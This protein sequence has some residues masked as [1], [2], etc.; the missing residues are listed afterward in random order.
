[1]S[2]P[3]TALLAR[4]LSFAGTKVPAKTQNYLD[5]KYVDSSSSKWIDVPNP[6][7]NE[8]VTKVPQ[9]TQAEME[10]AVESAKAAFKGWSQTSP[11]RRQEVMFKYQALI[12]ENLVSL[13]MF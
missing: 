8:V 2:S 6:A 5:G 13:L 9:N 11:L 4:N 10:Q 12:K 1:M 7:T 3:S